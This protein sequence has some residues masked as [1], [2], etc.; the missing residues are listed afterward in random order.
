VGSLSI[1]ATVRGGEAMGEEQRGDGRK[2]G[3]SLRRERVTEMRLDVRR[4][5]RVKVL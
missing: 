2:E 5:C 1:S 3:Q 4:D